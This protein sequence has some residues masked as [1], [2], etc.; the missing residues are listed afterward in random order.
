MSAYITLVQDYLTSVSEQHTNEVLKVYPNP[1]SSKATIEFEMCQE[2]SVVL[3]IYSHMGELVD[4]L[5]YNLPKG[6]QKLLWE[7]AGLP[8]G[9][10]FF[11]LK[12]G[13][14]TYAGKILKLK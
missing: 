6:R 9:F 1:F 3:N 5:R 4:A 8:Y 10:Y 14:L 12:I 13:N 7:P 2:G 11:S